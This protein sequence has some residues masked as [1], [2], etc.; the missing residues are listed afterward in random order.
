MHGAGPQHKNSASRSETRSLH[1]KK[2]VRRSV[3]SEFLYVIL[4]HGS[5]MHH[6]VHNLRRTMGIP[7]ARRSCTC[8]IGHAG[9]VYRDVCIQSNYIQLGDN[10]VLRYSTILFQQIIDTLSRTGQM[11]RDKWQ[12]LI[13]N[14]FQDKRHLT[15]RATTRA[16]NWPEG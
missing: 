10:T 3:K 4:P 8:R 1:S 7:L 9:I 2:T 5:W 16:E 12:Q 13:Q 14:T 11:R 6:A 15:R